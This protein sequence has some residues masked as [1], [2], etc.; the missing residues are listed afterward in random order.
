MLRPLAHDFTLG[1]IVL[2]EIEAIASLVASVDHRVAIES[3]ENLI[4]SLTWTDR[5]VALAARVARSV[6]GHTMR[7]LVHA[8]CEVV[9]ESH[10]RRY[11]S[12]RLLSVASRVVA[13]AQI[14]LSR[15]LHINLIQVEGILLI[16]L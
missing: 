9:G 13:A 16:V 12:A 7:A 15:V 8:N 6:F 1:I 2:G 4:V 11:D 5:H 14:E 10:L 3:V